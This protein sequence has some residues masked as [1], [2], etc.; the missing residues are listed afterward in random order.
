LFIG[1][2]VKQGEKKKKKPPPQNELGRGRVLLR[3]IFTGKGDCRIAQRM[4]GLG[5]R[6]QK[7][8][9]AHHE[10]RDLTTAACAKEKLKKRERQSRS[11]IAAREGKLE[12]PLK[13]KRKRS[14]RYA[15]KTWKKK[16]KKEA[17][18]R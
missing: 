12:N 11:S 3:P 10:K 18:C 14:P 13:K 15:R 4:V 16:I 5:G 7:K 9:F 8:G 6:E 17:L 1:R 2:S